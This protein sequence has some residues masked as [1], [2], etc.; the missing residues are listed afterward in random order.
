[1]TWLNSRVASTA[2]VAIV[3]AFPEQVDTVGPLRVVCFVH[4]LM[5]A[6]VH[7]VHFHFEH[8]ASQTW[9]G[10][11]AAESPYLAMRISEDPCPGSQERAL[12][13]I[14]SRTRQL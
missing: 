1:M 2:A 10:C 12:A 14:P 6:G 7:G 13:N 4:M 11:L 3:V 9:G 5:K 8:V